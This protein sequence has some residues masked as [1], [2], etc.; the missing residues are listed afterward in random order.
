MLLI[1]VERSDDKSM[2]CNPDVKRDLLVYKTFF[3]NENQSYKTCFSLPNYFCPFQVSKLWSYTVI[4]L[5]A[6]VNDYRQIVST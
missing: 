2:L 3:L 1:C 4:R 5:D 6:H